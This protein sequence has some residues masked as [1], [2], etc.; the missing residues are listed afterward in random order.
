MIDLLHPN[1]DELLAKWAHVVEQAKHISNWDTAPELSWLAEYATRCKNFLEIGSFRGQSAKVMLLANPV[2]E[3][4]SLDTWDDQ[5]TFEDYRHNLGPEIAQGRVRNFQGE[6]Q[7][8]ILQLS[9]GFDGCFIDGAHLEHLVAAD[10]GN[11]LPLMNVGALMAGHDYRGDN[12]VARG[13]QKSLVGFSN[14][15]ESIWAFRKAS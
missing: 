15:L 10:I 12:D 2:L 4:T 11:V 6:S 13:V 5:G 3:L 8:T 1:R 7:K 14:P 9:P